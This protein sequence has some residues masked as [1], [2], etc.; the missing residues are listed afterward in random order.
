[1]SANLLL[2]VENLTVRLP[3]RHGTVRAV[4]RV[5]FAIEKGKT[6]ALVGESGCGKSMLCRALAGILPG[7]AQLPGAWRMTFDG[8]NLARLSPKELTRLRG[9]EIG[10]VL[11]NPLASLNPVHTIGRQVSEPMLYHLGIA[12]SEAKRRTVELL[13]AVGIPQAEP[14]MKCYPHQLSGGMRQRVA[15]AIALSCDPK[16]LI[17]DEPTT[18]LDVTVQAEILDLLGRLQRDRGMS[19]LLV[20]HDLALVA[21]RAHH[22]AVMYAGRIVE[23]AP[24]PEL[25]AGMRM[26][27]T[28][29]LLEALPRIDAPVLGP[30]PAIVGQPPNLAAPIVGCAFA[31]RCAYARDLCREQEPSLLEAALLPRLDQAEPEAG[32]ATGF[33]SLPKPEPPRPPTLDPG[34]PFH[35]RYACW[36]P[37]GEEMP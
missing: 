6:L 20:S 17:A 19:I 29:A 14:R 11:Q 4:E 30:L 35:H 12:A 18:A 22:T 31:P 8:R 7:G 16:L 24:T 15:I 9:N 32:V 25:F 37:V 36:F 23:E 21:G 26:P 13:Q 27:Y 1:M 33:E 10:I 34:S 28:R 2:S 5:S 3:S